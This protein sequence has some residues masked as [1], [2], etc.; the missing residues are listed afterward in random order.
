M[1]GIQL[2]AAERTRQI[3]DEQWTPEHDD[4]HRNG[5]LVEAAVCYAEAAG[6][7][8]RGGCGWERVP[9]SWP[10]QPEWWKPSDDPNRNLV[11]SGA[12]I[13]AEVDRRQRLAA[14]H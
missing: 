7:Q 12:L 8:I 11:K 1:N 2:I 3:E 4:E 5:E 10:W 9:E 6:I 14:T 13:A